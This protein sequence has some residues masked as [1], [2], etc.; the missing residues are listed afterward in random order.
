MQGSKDH[1]RIEKQE[2]CL[3]FYEVQRDKTKQGQ[4]NLVKQGASI[5]PIDL[6]D[7]YHKPSI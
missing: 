1:T 3:Y 4:L 5:Y 7:D 6:T 2:R